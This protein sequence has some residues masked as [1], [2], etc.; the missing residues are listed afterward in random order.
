MPTY[1]FI[2]ERCGHRLDKFLTISK[3]KKKIK[4]PMCSFKMT[5]LVSREVRFKLL[6]DGFYKE[7][8]N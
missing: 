2:C 3:R 5:R 6:G 8:W 7:G 4:C 1:E